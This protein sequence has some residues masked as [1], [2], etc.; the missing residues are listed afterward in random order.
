MATSG[1]KD[2][3]VTNWDTLRFSWALASQDVAKNTS[4]ITWKL[5]LISGSD[6]A[7][8]SSASKAWSVT[9]NGAKYSGSN[10]VGI[11]NNATKTLASGSTTITHAAD[12]TKT[13]AYSFS[14]EFAI[15]FSGSS[16]G[17]FSGSGSGT[18]T[19]IPRAS[20]P[21]LITWPETTGDV[22]NFG[23]EIAIHM[24][25]KADTFTHTVRYTFGSLS[26]TIA[27]G[28]TTGTTWTIPLSFMDLLPAATKGSGLIYVDTYSGSTLVGTKY[29][30]FT[31]HVPASVKP[32]CSIQVLDGTNYQATYGNLVRGLSKLKVKVTGQVARSSPI[33]AYRSTA[34]GSTY[35]VAEFTTAALH[36]AGTT[37][38]SA[39]V[40]DKRGRTS[41]AA[42]ASFPVLDYASPAVTALS[43][44]R[45]QQNGTTDP[46][47]AY[48]KATFSAKIT[49]LNNKNSAAY[50]LRYKKTTATSWTEVAITAQAGKYTVTNASQIFAA[51]VNSSFDVE[52]VA[53]DDIGTATR[54]SSA[55]TAFTLMDWGVGQKNMAIGKVAEKANALEIGLRAYDQYGT[56]ISNGMSLYGGANSHIDAN[57]TTEHLILSALNTPDSS[58]WYVETIFYSTKTVTSDRRQTAMPYR[59]GGATYSRYYTAGAWTAWESEALAAWPVGS[60][61]L[62]YNHTNPATLFG[63]TWTRIQNTFLWAVDAN[64]DVGVT[65][66]EKTV[67]LTAAQMPKHNHGGT[68]T[69]AGDARTHAWLASGGSAMGYDTVDAGSG[70]AHN[71]MPPY[72]QVSV[73]RRTA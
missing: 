63:G 42:S 45:C 53:T 61:Y 28:V 37:T 40:T 44:Q 48:I 65:G 11:G 69:N 29:T 47:G 39:T 60:I 50:K 66:G 72:I 15:T 12:G 55:P 23:D 14:Q 54:S 7:I 70:E 59:R 30:G 52:V 67:T 22:G 64:G 51:D 13:F 16:L 62:A 33:A 8:S 32:T 19:T 4:R 58:L 24:N 6:G 1:Y 43:A 56:H 25:R 46:A 31:A 18:L 57:T 17:T 3:K 10:T 34:N 68:Y 73:W 2:V 21:S 5:E 20:Q 27:T 36:T 35:T 41:A 26:G 71:N 49:A 9:V 38:V